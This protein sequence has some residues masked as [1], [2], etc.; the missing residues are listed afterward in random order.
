MLELGTAPLQPVVPT[1]KSSGSPV[2]QGKA[3]PKQ[4]SVEESFQ[5]A[6]SGEEHACREEILHAN[7]M[8]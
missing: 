1:L 6:M 5:P 3:D 8:S 7:H 4:V 2:S